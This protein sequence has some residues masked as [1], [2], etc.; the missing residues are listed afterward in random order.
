ME[1]LT[2]FLD[3]KEKTPLYR[4]LYEAL[5]REILSG[6]LAAGEKLPSKRRLAQALQ[7]SLNTVDA[8][9]QMLTAEGYLLSRPRSGYVVRRVERLTVPAAPPPLPEPEPPPA[10]PFDLGTGGVEPALFPLK[11]W[12]RLQ[13]DVLAGDPDLLRRGH[14]QGDASL[15]QAIARYLHEARGVVCTPEQLVVGAGVEYLLGLL[16]RLFPDKTFALEDPGYRRTTQ[17]L[18]NN[19]V[20]TVPV[21]VDGEG[22]S[23]AGLEA[24]CAQVACLTPSHQFPTGATMPAGRRTEFLRW[25]GSVPGRLLIEDDYDSEFRFDGRPLPSLQGLDGGEHVIYLGTFS[26]GLAPGIRAAYMALPGWAVPLFRRRYDQ[27]A[28]TVSRPDQQTLRRFLEE[29]H[30][31]RHL[32]RCRTVYRARRDALIRALAAALGPEHVTFSG[33]H[34]GLHL[35]AEVRLGLSQEELVRRA[36][37]AGVRLSALNEYTHGAARLEEVPRLVLGYGA[38]PDDRVLPAAQAL[39]A[40]WVPEKGAI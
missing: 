12:R 25:A 3:P 8:A 22:L 26:R 17:V 30:Y 32:A 7:V 37:A 9:Y 40:A 36:R 4:Q 24:S 27:Y 19:G 1:D 14:P 13:R 20:H 33:E 31:A 38:L 21:P 18:A 5:S 34:T 6:S 28:C 39:A 35:L 11:T 10:W 15:R 2:L 23:L 29:G 16:A